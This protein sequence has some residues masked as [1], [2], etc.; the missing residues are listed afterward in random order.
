MVKNIIKFLVSGF[1]VYATAYLLNGV[2]VSDFKVALI[3]AL[4]LAALNLLVKP[5][6][7]ILSLPITILSL[8]LFTFVIDALM[9]LIASKIV[10]GFTVD[11][12]LTAI[13]FSLVLSIVSFVLHKVID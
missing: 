9:V 3:V 4:V 6:L 11:G 2:T 5:I 8:G 1:A 10:P 7:T 13:M 12:F